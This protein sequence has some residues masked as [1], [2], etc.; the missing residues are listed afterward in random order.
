M[1]SKPCIFKIGV[2]RPIHGIFLSHCPLELTAKREFECN[3]PQ[4]WGG[5]HMDVVFDGGAP[6][7]SGSL[8]Q[9]I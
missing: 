6:R 3:L 7:L 2:S 9:K 8:K 1:V 5:E 4:F